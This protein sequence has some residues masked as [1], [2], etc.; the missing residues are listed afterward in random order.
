MRSTRTSGVATREE[1][2]E[3]AKLNVTKAMER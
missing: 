3:K 2:I 1:S